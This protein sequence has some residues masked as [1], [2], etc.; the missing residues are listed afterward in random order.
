MM[1]SMWRNFPNPSGA[2]PCFLIF[3]LICKR[4]ERVALIGNNG[5]WKNN[6]AEDHQRTLSRQ[7][8]ASFPWVPKFRSDIMT[9]N[10]MFLHMDKT[11]FRKFPTRIRLLPKR[12]SEICSAAFL[13]T[14]DDVFKEISALSGGERGRVSLAKLM[15]SRKPI[16]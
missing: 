1:Y 8:P 15:L 3:L 4:G 9:R 7:M 14:G 16:S 2:E 6:D 10:I 5:T 12:R 11:I 13:F